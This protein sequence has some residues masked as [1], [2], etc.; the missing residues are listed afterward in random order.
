MKRY[1]IYFTPRQGGFAEAAA[2]WDARLQPV[3]EGFSKSQFNLGAFGNGMR[4]KLMANLL[5]AIH[6]VS[7]AEALLLGQ[8][9]GIKPKDAVK[10]LSDGAGHSFTVTASNGEANVTG[11]NLGSLTV[12][13]PTGASLPLTVAPA[14]GLKLVPPSKLTCSGPVVSRCRWT[15]GPWPSRST[16]SFTTGAEPARGAQ[17][18]RN[19]CSRTRVP[20][21]APSASATSWKP[22][23]SYRCRAAPSPAKVV[24]QARPPAWVST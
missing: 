15:P 7:T 6:N 18:R 5:V 13:P 16:I 12:T 10:V 23:V 19:S 14:T 3:F 20:Q 4:M 24:S 8:R 21:A 11:W 22:A 2:A 17:P 1:A 9:W